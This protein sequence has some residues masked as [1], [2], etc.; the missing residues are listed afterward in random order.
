MI[1]HYSINNFL[2]ILIWIYNQIKE[3]VNLVI[4]KIL[5]SS[6]IKKN[7]SIHDNILSYL[8]I[9]QYHPKCSSSSSVRHPKENSY[10]YILFIF[11]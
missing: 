3:N 6:I 4:I 10:I 8:L 2:I 11:L 1:F 7:R 5:K 9:F